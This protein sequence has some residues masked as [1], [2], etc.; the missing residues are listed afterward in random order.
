MPERDKGPLTPFSPRKI[1]IEI[2]AI[3]L[4]GDVSNRQAEFANCDF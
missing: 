2:F 4:E 3:V 1:E